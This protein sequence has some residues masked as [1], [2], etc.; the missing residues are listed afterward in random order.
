MCWDLAAIKRPK[1]SPQI[2]WEHGIKAPSSTQVEGS[3]GQQNH[4]TGVIAEWKQG[5]LGAP[6]HTVLCNADPNRT[7]G[8]VRSGQC[9][10]A[11]E[12]LPTGF[13][14]DGEAPAQRLLC[15]PTLL[16]LVQQVQAA[17][18]GHLLSSSPITGESEVGVRAQRKHCPYAKSKLPQR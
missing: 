3:R 17:W 7:P 1:P 13:P 11:T 10:A 2:L 15:P 9:R 4:G 14:G 8:F 18:V 5:A 12:K 6:T 16:L